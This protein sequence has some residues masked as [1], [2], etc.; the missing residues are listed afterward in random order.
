MS[1]YKLLVSLLILVL[2]PALS[3]G[4]GSGSYADPFRI[5]NCENLF[6]MYDNPSSHF[7]ITND[8]NCENYIFES[9]PVFS[10]SLEG[11]SFNVLNFFVNDSYFIYLNEGLIKDTH[12]EFSSTTQVLFENEGKILNRQTKREIASSPFSSM[13]IE[14][15]YNFDPVIT[16]PG[17]YTNG[18]RIPM[19]IFIDNKIYVM[20]GVV[21]SNEVNSVRVFDVA[22]ETW[23]FKQNMPYNASGVGI[24]HYDG[25]IYVTGRLFGEELQIYDIASDSW[26]VGASM[27]N[28]RFDVGSVA[29]NGKIYVIGGD[30]FDAGA[31]N[32]LFIYDIASNTWIEGPNMTIARTG[33]YGL[34]VF[35]DLIYVIG[36]YDHNWNLPTAV[37]V[38]NTTNN[39]WSFGPDLPLGVGYHNVINLAESFYVVGGYTENSPGVSSFI[40]RY[41]PKNDSWEVFEYDFG[42]VENS[43]SGGYVLEEDI[44]KLYIIG[45]YKFTDDNYDLIDVIYKTSFDK[46][47]ALEILSPIN[48]TYSNSLV[49]FN[50]SSGDHLSDLS[51]YYNSSNHSFN[52][53]LYLEFDNGFNEVVVYGFDKFRGNVSSVVSF[54]IDNK[55]P[56]IYN[57]SISPKGVLVNESVNITV[58][59]KGDLFANISYNNTSEI[60]SLV[61]GSNEFISDF[62]F[63]GIYNVS[64]FSN[65]SFNR[66]SLVVY[67][68]FESF[69]SNEVNI[70]SW[71][72][73][74]SSLTFYHKGVKLNS[75]ISSILDVSLNSSKFN[76][77]FLGANISL[78][79]TLNVSVTN[80]SDFGFILGVE[81][82]FSFNETT[83]KVYHSELNISNLNHLKL[84]KCDNFS[85]N[86]NTCFGDWYSFDFVNDMSEG[87]LEFKTSSFSAFGLRSEIPTPPPATSGSS[88]GGSSGGF[89]VT[90]SCVAVFEC[91]DWS[92]CL[93]GHQTRLCVKDNNLC[94]GEAPEQIKSCK[95]SVIEIIEEPVIE[96]EIELVE[97]TSTVEGSGLPTGFVVAFTP[98]DKAFFTLII[99]LGLVGV[100][101]FGYKHKHLLK[102]KEEDKR[103]LYVQVLGEKSFKVND[104]FVLESINDL[105]IYLPRMSEETFNHHVTLE[106]NDFSNWIRHVFLR[107][108]LADKV[109]EFKTKNELEEFLKTLN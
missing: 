70:S 105:K 80:N 60:L 108:D 84:Y 40:Q 72:V 97:E 43:V 85:Y 56:E 1:N 65:D 46:P 77:F 13:S 62:E 32:T 107:E 73:S 23:L 5:S 66:T 83:V 86:N 102:P 94:T 88:R 96:E 50:I 93:D 45:G 57:H 10:G 22:S 95:M 37:E 76:M 101:Y 41:T 39:S 69:N 28:R 103:Y 35:E 99:L 71:N 63:I 30:D 16:M 21:S 55:S 17:P 109:S 51:Y 2:L 74:N 81:S 6:L 38:Y 49:F 87:Y 19:S 36:G 33:E 58:F 78:N 7:F 68:S 4:F 18:V 89:T 14:D 12:I 31:T 47:S 106:K 90:N 26:S 64:I 53:S 92:E 98:N 25:K 52:E 29:L 24:S 48:I 79:D 75:L 9:L 104:G 61:N 82:S 27:P 11:N 91:S 8:L 59:G 34:G 20:G 54:F 3:S 15:T 44:F 42:L 67:D 100:S